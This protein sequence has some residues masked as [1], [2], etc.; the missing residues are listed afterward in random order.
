L[1]EHGGQNVVEVVSDSTC[2]GAE[3]FETLR[4]LQVALER[5]VV[6]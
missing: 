6:R 2:K 5:P 4:V 3:R 1:T